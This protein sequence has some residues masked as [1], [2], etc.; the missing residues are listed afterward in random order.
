LSFPGIEIAGMFFK[1]AKL[2]TVTPIVQRIARIKKL[3]SDKC[4]VIFT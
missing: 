3:R 1:L 4:F 2:A